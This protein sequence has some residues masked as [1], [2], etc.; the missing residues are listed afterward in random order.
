M[1]P[2]GKGSSWTAGM[3]PPVSFHLMPSWISLHVWYYTIK[4]GNFFYYD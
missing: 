4:S 2:V 1:L 3:Y